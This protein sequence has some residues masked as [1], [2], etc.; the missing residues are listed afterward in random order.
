M[1]KDLLEK[2]NNYFNPKP[3]PPGPGQIIVI[4]GSPTVS[5][6]LPFPEEP[7]NNEATI[8]NTDIGLI[9]DK[10]FEERAVPAA[11]RNALKALVK[12]ELVYPF[13]VDIGGVYQEVP[14][15]TWKDVL[16]RYNMKCEPQWANSGLFA[17]ELCHPVYDCLTPEERLEFESVYGLQVESNELMVYLDSVNSYMNTTVI[18]AHAEVYRFL[19]QYMPDSLKKFYPGLF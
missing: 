13:F 6:K 18:E 3:K 15:G 10:C 14:A 8:E 16:G 4:G 5:S 12:V 11:N 7:R 1:C 17:H 2:L 19:G 9:W